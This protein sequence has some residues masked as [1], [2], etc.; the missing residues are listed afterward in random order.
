M[1]KFHLVRGR[2]MSTLGSARGAGRGAACC[3]PTWGGTQ[4]VPG[5]PKPLLQKG[6]AHALWCMGT[7]RLR[8][9]LQTL[10]YMMVV[11][12]VNTAKILAWLHAVNKH[13]VLIDYAHP[14]LPTKP[15]RHR[16]APMTD[17]AVWR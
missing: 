3:A 13:D 16:S 1:R 9:W 8:A 15:G 10:P 2:A 12:A 11:N 4:R 14:W 5:L 6:F 7:S 17:S